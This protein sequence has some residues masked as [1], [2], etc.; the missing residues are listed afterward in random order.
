ASNSQKWHRI[1]VFLHLHMTVRM[2]FARAPLR[3]FKARLRHRMET[4]F[5]SEESFRLTLPVILHDALIEFV[6]VDPEFSVELCERVEDFAAHLLKETALDRSYCRLNASLVSRL[7][8]AGWQDS[9]SLMV[10]VV[11]VGRVDI[12]IIAVSL[13]DA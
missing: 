1:E 7:V 6:Q 2:H 8:G 9:E 3:D 5:L 12:R 13:L 10:P 11:A 4:G